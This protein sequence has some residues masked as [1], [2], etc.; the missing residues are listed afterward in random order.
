MFNNKEKKKVTKEAIGKLI[1]KMK[2]VDFDYNFAQIK[3]TFGS[4]SYRDSDNQ[5][6]LHLLVDDN[7]DE[8][9][10]YVAIRT[11]LYPQYSNLTDVNAKDD[12]GYN[13][14]QTALY[15][16]YSEEFI[17][18]IIE[19]ALF[20]GLDVN[21]VDDDKDTIMHTAIYS[22][23]YTDGLEDIY[24]LLSA[25]GFDSKLVDQDG[26]DLI[27]AMIY[28]KTYIT[29]QIE[30]LKELIK[31]NEC[32]YKDVD[33]ERNHVQVLNKKEYT[34]SPTV[35]RDL[36]VKKLITALA[37]DSNVILVGKNGVGKTAIVEELC[38]KIK[39]GNVP[40]CLKKKV[41]IKMSPRE[42]EDFNIQVSSIAQLMNLCEEKK[43]ILFVEEI[44]YV[45]EFGKN[46]N[47]NQHELF[48]SL[49]PYLSN[50]SFK[51]IGTTTEE[52]YEQYFSNSYARKVFERI[53]VQEPTREKL[54]NIV[55][56]IIDNYIE[57][58][59]II[60]LNENIKD[61]VIEVIVNSTC[62]ESNICRN[63]MS[64]PGLAASIIEKAFVIARMNASEVITID[65]FIESFQLNEYIHNL[66]R[67]NAINSLYELKEQ[68]IKTLS[69]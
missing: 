27:D 28:Q 23:N 60:F 13:F 9:K 33:E 69:K 20:N 68:K 25:H 56:K 12:F 17:C 19:A 1:S 36:E 26:R 63:N 38:S 3:K 64:N 65:Y 10:C 16:G 18:K 66:D 58:T 35:E 43:F 34:T 11:L 53:T 4:I 52:K 14:I 47:E 51:V 54:Y 32:V 30:S 2:W 39:N 40:D 15:T 44:D 50:F 62:S 67:D 59:N 61:K 29:E 37:G 24:K 49:I 5:T 7:Y 45:Y 48:R 31:K 42:L 46:E 22:D 55:N 41:I 6:I 8:S 57:Q 21:I